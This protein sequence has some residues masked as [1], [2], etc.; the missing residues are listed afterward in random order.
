[1]DIYSNRFINP[2]PLRSMDP[3]VDSQCT[4]P[5]ALKKDQSFRREKMD[6]QRLVNGMRR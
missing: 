3:L 1:M 4:S 5:P 2:G 6:A